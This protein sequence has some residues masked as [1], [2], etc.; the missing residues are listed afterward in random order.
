MTLRT[1]KT[2]PRVATL[3]WED[4]KL[5][6]WG[7]QLG[8]A[9]WLQDR[10]RVLAPLDLCSWSSYRVSAA[11]SPAQ[12]GRGVW[13]PGRRAAAPGACQPGQHFGLSVGLVRPGTAALLTWKNTGCLLKRSVLVRG[14]VPAQDEQRV[15]LSPAKA[16]P[17]GCKFILCLSCFGG[18]RGGEQQGGSS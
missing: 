8:R 12:A 18:R 7:C 14:I 4:A 10:R 1:A 9:G 6:Q 15:N 13:S 11:G 2:L 3:F 17:E 16:N 5:Y